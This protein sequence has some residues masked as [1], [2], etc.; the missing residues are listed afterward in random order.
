MFL[1]LVNPLEAE[2]EPHSVEQIAVKLDNVTT[3]YDVTVQS[4]H[5]E[6]PVA[7]REVGHS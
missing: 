6:L 2:E 7:V 4:T 3:R 5:V 1:I